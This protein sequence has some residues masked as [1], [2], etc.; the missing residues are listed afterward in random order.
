MNL[1]NHFVSESSLREMHRHGGAYTWTNKQSSPIMAILDRVFISVDWE[2][3]FSLATARSLTRVGA[4]HNPLLVETESEVSIRSTIFR[5]ENAWLNQEGFREWVI[6]K[7]PQR[8]K[9]YILDH[10]NI[11]SSML[12]KTMKG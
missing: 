1:F 10:W 7:W 5:F 3:H 4:D 2:E 6:S 12:R 9:S 8:H 11:V